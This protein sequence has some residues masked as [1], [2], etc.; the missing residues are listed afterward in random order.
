MNFI[1]VYVC[2]RRLNF[3]PLQKDTSFVKSIPRG[4][5]SSLKV[6][7]SGGIASSSPILARPSLLSPVSREVGAAAM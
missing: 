5:T 3:A 6:L 7:N 4:V 2:F 1:I